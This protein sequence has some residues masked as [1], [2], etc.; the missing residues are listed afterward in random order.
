MTREMVEVVVSCYSDTVHP[1]AAIFH[2]HQALLEAKSEWFKKA[3]QPQFKEGI[4]KR[5][6]LT[7]QDPDTFE[8]FIQWL[9]TGD[10]A[11]PPSTTQPLLPFHGCILGD[12]LQATDFTKCCMDHLFTTF[13]IGSKAR[14]I[15][16]KTV[17]WVYKSTSKGSMLRKF[18]ALTIATHLGSSRSASLYDSKLGWDNELE[19]AQEFLVDLLLAVRLSLSSL[20]RHHIA[21][22]DLLKLKEDQKK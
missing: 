14:A 9:Y 20:S 17:D 4:Q 13:A 2:V 7:D 19:T 8:I 10:F 21:W 16:P 3:L 6:C 1:R 5:V 11:M 12:F 22:E 18:V 15:E